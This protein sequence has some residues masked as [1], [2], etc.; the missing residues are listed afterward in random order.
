MKLTFDRQMSTKSRNTFD[1]FMAICLRVHST[2]SKRNLRLRGNMSCTISKIGPFNHET[3]KQPSVLIIFLNFILLFLGFNGQIIKKI[4]IC[5]P[6]N[7]LYWRMNDK[8]KNFTRCWLP[9]IAHSTSKWGYSCIRVCHDCI[10][11]WI[12]RRWYYENKHVNQVHAQQFSTMKWTHM[13]SCR[14]YCE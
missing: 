4:L 2:A 8:R 7:L 5:N 3:T 1:L 6:W 14:M 12:S 11:Y 13:K 10:T 9:T